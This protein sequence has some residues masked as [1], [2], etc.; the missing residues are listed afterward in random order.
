M[1]LR[2]MIGPGL[3]ALVFFVVLSA[4]ALAPLTLH[5][6]SRV[7]GE[8]PGSA[9]VLDY[10]H[11]H[12]NLWWLR[13]A[14]QTGQDPFYTDMVLAPFRH[15]LTYHSLTASLLPVYVIFE[16]LAGHLRTANG[17]IW[18]CLALTGWLMAV[19]L[20]CKGVSRAVA[21]LGGV[22]LALAPYILDHAASG[23]LNLLT[24]FW[25]PLVLLAWEKFLAT[26]AIRWA[27]LTG[28]ILWGMW[29]TDTLIVLWGGLLL[30]PYA[31]LALVQ[32]RDG[33]ARWR[34]V[35]LGGLALVITL[36]L[37]WIVGPL[38]QTLD[39]E[40]GTLPPARLVTLRAYALP[41]D[42]LFFQPGRGDASLGIGLVALVWA[43]L[44]VRSQHRMR[45]F[46]LAAGLIPL[47]LALGPDVSIL[48][49]RVPLPFRLIHEAFGGQMRTPI[50][51]LPA[52]L[53]GLITFAAL[54]FDPWVRRVRARAL[55]AA[56]LLL[57][58]LI[59][60][61][62]F[63]PL[64]TLPALPPYDLYTMMRGEQYDDYD[65]VVLDVP[66]GPF[67]G[68]RDVGS[69]P[70][71]MVYGITH[72]KRMVSGLL[73]RIPLED[74]LYYETSPLF[75]WLTGSRPL[76]AGQAN[77]ELIRIVDEWPL[78]YVVVHQGWLET[79]RAEEILALFNAHA[80]LCYL[81]TE[82]DAVLYRTTSHPKGCPPRT[83]PEAEPGVYR[84]EI[85]APG[86]EGFIGH[87]W[88]WPEDFGGLSMRWAGGGNESLLYAD[89]PPGAAYELVIRA[90]AFHEARDVR[91][92][93]G[94]LVDGAPTGTRLET[95]SV[96]PGE[97][98]T[99]RVTIPADLIERVGGRLVIALSADHT[100]SAA[101]VGLSDDARPLTLGYDWAELRRAE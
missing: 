92:T 24:V 57:V 32:A 56:G 47:V 79:G 100:L 93:V 77:S 66:P 14:V 85:G 58:L 2:R 27:A 89:V 45:W 30:G 84:I 5:L 70:E 88:F 8:P 55:L 33:R 101:E 6:N 31:L 52:A 65:Y 96:R 36:A 17:I 94:D 29:L 28:V 43:G 76:D 75:G 59:D 68:W 67:T 49:V 41:L 46:W 54:T 69:H 19:F 16:P 48:G 12:W 73:S 18:G 25:I 90:L 20:R 40:T 63:A 35:L 3:L 64:P 9:R 82:R 78:G 26:R 42:A 61:R 91:V 99:Y 81:G 60:F 72:E 51:F 50:R 22:A 37:A 71:A 11:F 97:W 86:D 87:G 83:P 23:H 38:R 95:L 53:V 15:N 39:F 80:S 44:F 98:D 1:A 4:I 34:L 7:P 74:H 13:H 62:A 10:Y 21:L